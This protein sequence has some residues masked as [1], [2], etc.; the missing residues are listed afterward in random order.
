[1]VPRSFEYLAA[2]DAMGSTQLPG[3]DSFTSALVH[4]LETLVKEKAEGRFTTVELVKRIRLHKHF[5]NDQTPVLS[6]R[7]TKSTA[8]RIMLHPLKETSSNSQSFPKEVATLDPLRRQTLTLHFDFE[9]K[10]S[11]TC[12]EQLGRRLNGIFERDT[13]GVNGVRWGGVRQPTVT[14]ALKA[15]LQR[16]RRLAKRKQ[17]SLDIGRSEKWLAE[18]VTGPLTPSSSDH[19]SLPKSSDS[20]EECERKIQDHKGR[21]KRRK[22]SLNNRDSSSRTTSTGP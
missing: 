21:N 8:G 13:L 5:P 1:M 22:S 6:D 20:S 16:S 12:I 3:P 14:R 10:P 15:S 11:Q 19:H 7:D 17:A 4:A 9:E 2:T 18:S